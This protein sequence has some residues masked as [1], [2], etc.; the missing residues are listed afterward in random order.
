MGLSPRPFLVKR[1]SLF[2]FWILDDLANALGQSETLLHR[3]HVRI[4]HTMPTKV[5]G[6]LFNTGSNNPGIRTMGG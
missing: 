3:R 1:K 5:G 4:H 6:H 2:V